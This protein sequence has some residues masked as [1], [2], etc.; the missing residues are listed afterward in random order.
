VVATVNDAT[1]VGSATGTLEITRA[2]QT[3]SFAAPAPPASAAFG[4]TFAV[5]ATATSGLPVALTTAGSCALTAGADSARM[6]SGGGDCTIT[7]GQPGNENVAPAQS[8]TPHRRSHQGRA[9]DHVRRHP[10]AHVR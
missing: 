5:R 8:V 6:T 7:A 9:D 1:Y 3:V 10:G 4:T 2:T